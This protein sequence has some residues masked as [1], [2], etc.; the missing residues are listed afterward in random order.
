M[1]VTFDEIVSELSGVE[2]HD[3]YVSA[4]CCFHDDTSPSMLV[5]KDG[6]FKCMS[7]GEMGN[8]T[9]LSKQLSGWVPPTTISSSVWHSSVFPA[10]DLQ[11]INL[12]CENAH[13]TLMELYDPLAGYLLSRGLSERTIKSNV[14]GY[15]KGWYTIPVWDV[16]DKFCGAVARAGRSITGQRFN[17]P[18][19]QKT[20]V[21]YPDYDGVLESEYLIVVYGMF[22]A[23]A[24]YELGYP[25]CTPTAGK[26]SLHGHM[27]E[28]HRKHIYILPDKGEE[29]T[30]RKLQSELGWRGH[31][32]DFPYPSD[33]KDPND[34]LVNGHKE[35]LKKYI[36]EVRND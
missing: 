8:L 25:V 31:V 18:R 13:A 35:L 4:L 36:K 33:S 34:L 27:L 10:G 30:A 5:Y 2:D 26:G 32:L 14:L 29:D 12:F 23:L 21:Y 20:L 6:F 7:C 15:S 24:M 17:I 16:E 22:D 28:Q 9:K 11:E 1:T 19:G 3:H